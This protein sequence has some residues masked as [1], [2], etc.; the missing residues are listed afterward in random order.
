MSVLSYDLGHPHTPP[1]PCEM[2]PPTLFFY[3]LYVNCIACLHSQVGEGMGGPKSYDSTETLVLY[4]QY[5]LYGSSAIGIR[6]VSLLLTFRYQSKSAIAKYLP[7]YDKR[8]SIVFLHF[9]SCTSLTPP[10]PPEPELVN[11]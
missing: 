10:P 8:C 2:A 9:P 5:S 1:F 6:L 7:S 11:V 3:S 4:M